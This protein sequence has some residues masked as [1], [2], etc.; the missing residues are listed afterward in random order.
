MSKQLSHKLVNLQI[1]K[2]P[3]VTKILYLICHPQIKV[4]MTKETS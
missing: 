3:C 1:T 4:L 2:S